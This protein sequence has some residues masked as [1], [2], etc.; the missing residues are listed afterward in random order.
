VENSHGSDEKEFYQQGNVCTDRLVMQTR[1][2]Q[3]QDAWNG[4]RPH[5]ALNYLT[6]NEYF[7]KWQQ[8][9]L[10]TKDTIILQA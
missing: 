4:I 1:L 10:P 7:L 5:A 3:W 9:R 8:G 2:K 6:P